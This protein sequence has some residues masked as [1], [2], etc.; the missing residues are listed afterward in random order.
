MFKNIFVTFFILGLFSGSFA[1]YY[2]DFAHVDQM[3]QSN[4]NAGTFPGAVLSVFGL[5]ENIYS[6]SYGA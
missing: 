3:F 5:S 1:T 4:I 6:Q 2:I